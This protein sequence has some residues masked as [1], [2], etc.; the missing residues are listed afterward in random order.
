MVVMGSGA[1]PF[2]NSSM[3]K[4]NET[5]PLVLKPE[6]G[7][8]RPRRSDYI[9]ILLDQLV[10][11]AADSRLNAVVGSRSSSR[12]LEPGRPKDWPRKSVES[13][14]SRGSWQ[15]NPDPELGPG[16]LGLELERSKDP[17]PLKTFSASST[18]RQNFK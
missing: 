3:T 2:F 8:F 17:I 4:L 6:H 18:L 9:L 14:R 12:S 5:P 10:M 13:S 7:G 16:P 15:G 1:G 11:V